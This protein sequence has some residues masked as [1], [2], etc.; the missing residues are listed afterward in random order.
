MKNIKKAFVAGRFYPGNKDELKNLIESFKKETPPSSNYQ[1]RAIIVPHAGYIYSGRL[2]VQGFQYLDKNVKTVFV[3]SPAHK[4]RV[5]GCAIADYEAFE[6]P[7]GEIEVNKESTKEIARLFKC[8][9]CNDAFETEH[10]IEVQLPLI[11][12]F[13]PNAKIVPII[14]GCEDYKNISEILKHLWQNKENGFV[15]SSDLSHFYPEKDALRVDYFTA[16]LI[17]TNE[18][19]NFEAD[20]A[21]GAV[22]ICGIA[23]FAKENDFSLVRVGVTNSG[24]ITG[25]TSSVVG[26]GSWFLY[27]SGKNEY[28]K[29]YF[30]KTVLDICKS[31]IESGLQLGNSLPQD[32]PEVLEER[33]ACFVTLKIHGQLRGCIGSIIAHRPLM[34]DLIKNAH[35]A[36]FSDPRFNSLTLDEFETLQIEVSLLSKPEKIDFADED[37][38]LNKITP[39]KDGLILR[40]GCNQGVYL[41]AVWEQLPDKKVFLASLKVKAGIDK[42]Q[43]RE[44][45]D[46]QKF[47]TTMIN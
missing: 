15:I 40:D 34:Q 31:S 33:G 8:K 7:L 19:K 43:C 20:M 11:Q 32:Y 1:S 17:E 37:D 9:V 42:T 2:A 30:S 22:G 41:P 24:E 4:E 36:A 45:L 27:E 5:F 46:A 23:D 26:Y 13:L 29:E 25:D 21:C 6:T 10:A 18:V 47:Y 39:H 38:L 44:S 16:N 3:I 12:T 28:I 35:A 14:Y